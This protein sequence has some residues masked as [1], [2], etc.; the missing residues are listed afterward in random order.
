V[1][2]WLLVEFMILYDVLETLGG[3][4][5]RRVY[6]PF[7]FCGGAQLSSVCAYLYHLSFIH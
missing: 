5:A 6:A 1:I 4:T 2:A 3:L 7:F